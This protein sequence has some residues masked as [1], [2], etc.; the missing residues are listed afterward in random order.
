MLIEF[1]GLDGSGKSTHLAHAMRWLNDKG[2][3][4]FERSLRGT[5]K[6]LLGAIA[7]EAGRTSGRELFG[8]DLVE[9]SHAVEMVIQ[10]FGTIACADSQR[11][12]FL[13]DRYGVAWLAD[14]LAKGASCEEALVAIYS[15]LPRPT[16]S[17]Y[18]DVA[19]DVC[20]RRISERPKGDHKLGRGGR[21][22]LDRLYDAYESAI[23][24][25]PWEVVRINGNDS[26]ET[27]WSSV[28]DAVR[29][30]LPVG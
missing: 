14:A 5:G 6:R 19:P 8:V 1:C 23:G 21:A 18:L 24:A 27:V 26:V 3:L 2:Y 28:Q 29:N 12:M 15:R 9:F 22:A 17:I 7:H 20:W 11:T 10:A 4:A 25:L 16:C 30:R 13:A